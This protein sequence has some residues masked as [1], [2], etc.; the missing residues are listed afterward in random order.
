MSELKRDLGVWGAASIVVGTVIGSGIFL[1]PKSMVQNVGSAEM[2]IFVFVFGGLL[3]L[4]GALTYAEL[5]AAM[6]EAG[7]EYVYLREAYGPFFAFLYGWTQMWVAKS[8]SIATLATAFFTYMANFFP[9]LEG[10]ITELHLPLLGVLTVKTGQIFAMVVIG[11]LGW[12]NYFGVKIGGNVQVGVTVVKVGLI[13]LLIVVGLT[14][15]GGNTA[16]FTSSIPAPGG[17]AGFFAALVA[18]LWAYDGWNNVSMVSSEV[19]KP[20]KNLPLALVFGTLAVMA[21]YILANLAY[22]YVLSAAEVA[23]SDRVA[24]EM[25]R[26]VW[27]AGGANAVS[28]AA[29][30]SIFAALNGSILTGSRVPYAMARDGL[31]FRSI[32]EVHPKYFTPANS[33]IAL[34]A[35]SMVLILSGGYDQLFTYVIFASWILYGMAT[36]SV[37]VL[38][39]KRPDMPRPYRAVGYPVVPIVFVLVAVA[40]I[41]STLQK[42]PRESLL[43]LGIMATGIPFYLYWKRKLTA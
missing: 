35:W 14:F 33:I 30:I 3:S 38:R 23:A 40:L 39:R 15:S 19:K 11:L 7:G 18:A 2:V 42:S 26:R 12:L 36:A 4:A 43:G 28:V 31:F 41:L 1:V 29:M 9:A 17:I 16:N 32:G 10:V 21:I 5:S 8:G 6:P 25:M 27:G 20:Q 13:A 24:A 37:L 34:S 22:F